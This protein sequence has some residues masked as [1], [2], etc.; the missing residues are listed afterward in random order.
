MAEHRIAFALQA[1]PRSMAEWTDLA[2]R[3]ESGGFDALCVADHPGTT[4][5][6]FVSL[7]A[8]AAVTERIQLGTAVVNGG[9]CEPM[10]LAADVATL[11]LLSGGRAYLGLG[12]GHTPA[13]WEMVGRR[14]P[15]PAERVDRFGEL[16][17]TVPALVAGDT[18]TFSGAHL[19]LD[20]A[21]LAFS[22]G[23]RVPLLVGGSNPRLL[24]LGAEQ[25]DMVEV[26]GTGRTLA[27]GHSHEARWSPSDVARSTDLVRAAAARAGRH[28]VL[29]AL[30]QFAELTDDPE[31]WM[32]ARLGRAGDAVPPEHLPSVAD[33]LASPYAM[34]GSLDDVVAKIDQGAARW[35]LTR[36]TLRSVEVGAQVIAAR[37]AA[38]AR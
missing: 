36:Y 37:R 7:A 21:R 24:R 17:A 25:A 8:A 14:Y 28:V 13:E 18:V 23:R 22:T 11:D 26:S 12:A 27:D 31:G 2:R 15:S 20:G 34:V 35:G 29:G 33:A 1:A 38:E 9:V 3:A 6:P 30:V 5:S 32:A 19:Q 4:K 10:T 16:L